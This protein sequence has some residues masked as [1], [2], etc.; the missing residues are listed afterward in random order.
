MRRLI[1][2][3]IGVGTSLVIASLALFAGMR[4]APAQASSSVESAVVLAPV[5]IDG[6]TIP[7]DND[8]ATL[9]VSGGTGVDQVGT[10]GSH[11]PADLPPAVSAEI[12]ALNASG[13][14]DPASAH[15]IVGGTGTGGSGTGSGAGTD[16]GGGSGGS[17]G[18]SGGSAAGDPC[19]PSS[20]AAPSDCPGGLRSAIFAD[21]MPPALEVWPVADVATE[22]VGTSIYC[23]GLTPGTGELGLGVGTSVP[24]AVTVRYWPIA[25]PTDVHTVIP[26]ADASQVADWNARV[27]ATGTYPVHEFIFQHCGLLTGLRPHTDYRLSAV[28]VDDEFTR[29]S[30]PVER[31]FSS[32]GQPTIPPLQAVPLGNSLLYVSAPNY[33]T[34]NPPIVNAWVVSDGQPADC[35]G[36]SSTRQA[37]QAVQA[38]SLVE[39]STA[40]LHAHNYAEGY[41]HAMVAVYEVPEGSTVVAC[42][43]WYNNDAPSW[44]RD[45][46]T[47]QEFVVAM[48]PDIAA[49]RITLTNLSLVHSVDPLSVSIVASTR[50]GNLC[51]RLVEPADSASAGLL[52]VNQLLCDVGAAESWTAQLGSGLDMVISA[53][54][55]WSGSVIHS[56]YLL[57]LSRY[58]CEGT[59]ALPPTLTYSVPLPIVRVG[60]GMCS[61]GFGGD[62]TPPTRETALGT[63]EIRVDWTQ[64]NVNG[65]D[66][67][68]VGSPDDTPPAA[69]PVPDAPRLDTSQYVDATLSADGW[70]GSARFDL[71]ADRHVTYTASIAGTCWV[72]TPPAAA[73]GDTRFVSVGVYGA[74]VYFSGLCPGWSYIV[75]VELVD[76]AGHRTV[77]GASRDAGTVWWPGA[78]VSVPDRLYAVTASLQVSTD[79]SFSQAWYLVGGQVSYASDFASD[80]RVDFGAARCLSRDQFSIS[81][82]NDGTAVQARTVHVR[83]FARAQAEALYFGVNHDA[84]CS[85]P[86]PNNFV[87]DDEFDVAWTDLLRGVTVTGDLAQTDVTPFPGTRPPMHYRLTLRLGPAR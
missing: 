13:G 45:T 82:T 8:P 87:A 72:G 37:L 63:A 25:D 68:V 18:S 42:A 30:D 38:P 80:S 27:A 33:G 81:G 56:S 58:A 9:D 10:P 69:P 28:A 31:T 46:P 50:F 34:A 20:G 59:C 74:S 2:P 47:K 71:R 19:S 49:P 66:H 83:V 53:D 77:A 16:S 60:A 6:Q 67:W 73:S 36:F 54:V 79:P 5:A 22:P 21:T 17:G 65:L 41:N 61:S 39:V 76:D 4:F 86:G 52:D 12:A 29:V 78:I 84:D 70:S 85:W 23:P 1:R 14:I 3:L 26:A 64:G 55:T 62:C 24:A 75:T 15:L 57:P 51:G 11:G 44:E 48:S 7:G 35:S 32:D 43:R 40:Y